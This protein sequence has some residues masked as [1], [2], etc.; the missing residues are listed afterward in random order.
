VCMNVCMNLLISEESPICDLY[1]CMRGG[2]G[3]ECLCCMCY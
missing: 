1:E 3:S 2:G